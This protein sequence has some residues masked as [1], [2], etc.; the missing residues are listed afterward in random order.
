M[1]IVIY[2][3]LSSKS[4]IFKFCRLS[5]IWFIVDPLSL[6]LG[7]LQ[8]WPWAGSQATTTRSILNALIV[9]R[10]NMPLSQYSDL[11]KNISPSGTAPKIDIK[12]LA[13]GQDPTDHMLSIT[14][15][16]GVWDKP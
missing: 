5:Q 9:S 12:T 15:K 1:K 6:W 2:L 11:I 10:Y 7:I 16:D 4:I 13:F 3:L 8:A 14:S